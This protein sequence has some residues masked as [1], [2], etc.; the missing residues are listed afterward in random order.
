[1]ES[2]VL[3]FR[4][5]TRKIAGVLL[6]RGNS[7]GEIGLVVT[8]CR[9]VESQMAGNADYAGDVVAAVAKYLAVLN[10][11][12]SCEAVRRQNSCW[13]RRVCA[14]VQ[15]GSIDFSPAKRVAPDD[16]GGDFDRQL[17]GFLADLRQRGLAES[18][19]V[20]WVK[21]ARRFMAYLRERGLEGLQGLSVD[22]VDG[23]VAWVSSLHAGS[24][25][26]GELTMLRA[27]LG[28]SDSKGTTSNARWLVPQGRNIRPAPVPALTDDEIRAVVS[29]VDNSSKKGKRDLAMIL[30]A[31]KM[32]IRESEITALRMG[33][34]NWEERT[35]LVR[36]KKTY[37]E[38]LLPASDDVL[39]ALA[40]YIL[41]ARPGSSCEEVFLIVRAPFTPFARG[42][43]LW[44][45]CKPYFDEAGVLDGKTGTASRAGL[46]RMRH[47]VATKLLAANTPPESIAAVLGHA[48]VETTMAY[49]AID[50]EHLRKCCLDLPK[51]GAGHGK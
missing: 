29:K 32:G 51:G 27:L 5:D 1:M 18:T 42:C 24:G 48:K 17:E 23:F 41:N 43:E 38:L 7:P 30:L 46:H 28:Y 14:F 26:S 2:N 40:D 16:I 49:A 50:G 3:K 9:G 25:L 19:Q 33:D 10:E 37:G 6:E 11:K 36:Q 31:A 47:S 15:N 39:D 44:N 20:K 4:E 21:Y 22:D 35:I 45:T 12:G 8:F 13:G 34:I